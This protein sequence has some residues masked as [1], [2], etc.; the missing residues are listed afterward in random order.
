MAI[1]LDQDTKWH[2]ATFW[3]FLVSLALALGLCFALLQLG[4]NAVE[5]LGVRPG[6][7]TFQTEIALGLFVVLQALALIG[8]GL[9]AGAGRVRGAAFGA[10][11]GLLSGVM[12]LGCL[13]SGKLAALFASF[14][15]EPLAG[16]G[17]LH[18][19]EVY[20]FPLLH[21]ISGAL[22]GFLAS[23]IWKPVPPL[24]VWSPK[25][26]NEVFEGGPHGGPASIPLLGAVAAYERFIW[27]QQIAW[28]PI[29]GGM[30]IAIVLGAWAPPYLARFLEAASEG[31]VK[32]HTPEQIIVFNEEVFAFSVL[33]GGCLAGAARS[34]GL[35]QGFF[36]GIGVSLIIFA[37]SL[38]GVTTQ[39]H[40]GGFPIA[41]AL[42]LGPLGGWFG[43]ELIPPS[44]RHLPPS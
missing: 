2:Q 6:Q 43:S 17:A 24:P 20:G 30:V 40:W 4:R 34:Q 14:L 33:V 29:M 21:M 13:V 8:A 23:R 1:A 35:T 31:H 39:W 27:W 5:I 12:V 37:L 3:R 18:P 41:S 32:I 11:V 19:A 36:V 38:V 10:F 22:G 26:E 16:V 25:P 28:F 15:D 42:I 44:P 9:V 7:G